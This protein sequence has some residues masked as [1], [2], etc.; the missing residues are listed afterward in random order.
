[1]SVQSENRDRRDRFDTNFYSKLFES[2]VEGRSKTKRIQSAAIRLI[3]SEMIA[4]R[5]NVPPADLR[6][7]ASHLGVQEVL[8]VPLA[9]RGRLLMDGTNVLIEINEELDDFRRKHTVAHELAHLVLEKDRVAVARAAGYNVDKP[10]SHSLMEQLCDL[11][12]DE[13]LLPESWLRDEL[14]K[15]RSSLKSVVEIALH[16]ELSIEFVV[17]RIIDLELRPWRAIWCFNTHGRIHVSKSVPL[18][19]ESFLASVEICDS[20][21][22]P[23]R[24]CW[25]CSNITQGNVVL[26]IHGEQTCYPAQCLRTSGDAALCILYTG[27][28]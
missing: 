14:T 12:A 8:L 18:W 21:D 28:R 19:D 9:S 13:V 23:L 2:A 25:S 24:N 10:F 17:T 15:E 5:S 7:L 22:S 11:C 4:A 27:R 3:N 6:R 16:A 26:T 1:M 20:G